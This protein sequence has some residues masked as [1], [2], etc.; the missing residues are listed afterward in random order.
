M[1]EKWEINNLSARQK[2][3]E[4]VLAV[5]EATAVHTWDEETIIVKRGTGVTTVGITLGSPYNRSGRRLLV[6]NGDNVASA[7]TLTA[8]QVTREDGTVYQSL[9]DGATTVVIAKAYG[10]VEVISDGTHFNVLAS[11]LT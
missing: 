2:I 11:N 8:P 1:R 9:I 7:I 4:D 6:K 5:R 3:A 10:T